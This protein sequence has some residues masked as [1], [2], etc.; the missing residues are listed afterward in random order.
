MFT[1]KQLAKIAGITPRTLH[2]YDETGLLKP[3]QV[4]QNGYRYYG[5]E[6]VLCLQQI[7][8]YRELDLP[9]NEIRKIMGNHEFDAKAA[10]K[11]HKVELANRIGRLE[12]LIK[13]V[14]QTLL[15]MEGNLEMSQKQLF[16]AFNDELQTEMEK[17]ALQLYDPEIVKA[18]MKKW[19]RYSKAEKQQIADEG[20][21]VYRDILEAMPRGAGSPEVQACIESWRRHMDYFWTPNLEQLVGLADGYNDDPRF[22][23]NFDKVE[24]RGRRYLCARRLGFTCRTKKNKVRLGND[25]EIFRK[26]EGAVT[27]F[28]DHSSH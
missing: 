12:H 22:R 3:T 26:N 28:W 16:E 19:K 5:E 6:S 10:L 27:S 25:H 11:Q 7:L 13:T 4:G 18:S 21:A 17:E 9:L 23:A 15:H 20:N 2:Y 24:I 8:F 1:V 14:D